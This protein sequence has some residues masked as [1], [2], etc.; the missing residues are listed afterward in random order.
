MEWV[1]YEGKVFFCGESR[2]VLNL[3]YEGIFKLLLYIKKVFVGVMIRLMNK[4][5]VY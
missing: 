4:F 1:Y 2:E 3:L 5:N